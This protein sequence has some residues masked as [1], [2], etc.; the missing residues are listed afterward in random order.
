MAE[1]NPDYIVE[2]SLAIVI[3]PALVIGTIIGFATEILK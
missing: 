2:R 1:M 3:I